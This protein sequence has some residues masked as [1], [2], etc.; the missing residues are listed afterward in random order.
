[1]DVGN[2]SS[3]CKAGK[4]NI[5]GEEQLALDILADKLIGNALEQSG[6]VSVY[7]SEE[8]DDEIRTNQ[9][10]NHP[11]A[12]GRKPENQFAVAY[13]PLDGS[14]LVDVNLAVGS[15]FGIYQE[16]GLKPISTFID[17]KGG[18]QVAAVIAI[19]GPRVT[20]IVTTGK[21]VDEFT[22]RD[23][24]EFE[25]SKENI[26]IKKQAK[27]FAPG[28]LRAATD[29]PK[30]FQLVE[31]WIKN[32]YTL[33]YSGGMVPDI[34]HILL[35]EQGIF[36]YPAPAKL[37]LLFEAA[38]IALIMEAA[39]G[40]ASDGE[41]NLLDITI[42]KINQT[43]PVILGSQEEVVRAVEMLKVDR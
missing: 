8:R 16:I 35:K 33:R 28:N 32:K 6:L 24:G 5:F 3:F 10:A 41:Q 38:P 13:D 30:Y 25:L 36:T 14:S 31:Y 22:L 15:I 11:D 17:K 7:A 9:P 4:K 39:G 40:G 34:N 18:N 29:N 20:L 23:N 42:K 27:N 1:M 21:Q 26:K 37:R 43:T 2:N 19:Y 12:S